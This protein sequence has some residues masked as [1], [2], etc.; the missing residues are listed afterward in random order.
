MEKFLPDGVTVE[1]IIT[2][3]AALATFA[4][5]MAIWSTGVIKDNMHGK[6]K[7]LQS[8]RTDLKR[9]YTTAAKRKETVKKKKN[10]GFMHDVVNKIDLIKNEAGV[11][12]KILLLQAGFRDK[13]ALTIFTFYKIIAPIAFGVISVILIYVVQI[14]EL[15]D[16]MKILVCLGATLFGAQTPE[17]YLKNLTGK[18]NLE[19]QR[20]LPDMLDL[21]VICSEAGLTLDAALNRVVK[22]MSTAHPELADEIAL[23]T[24]ELGFL[25]DRKTA[26]KNL[27]KRV[28]LPS[29]KA[30]SATLIQAEKYGTPLSTSLRVL[31]AEFRNERFMKA[32]EK[33]AKLPATMTIPLIMFILPTLFI[34]LMGPAACQISDNLVK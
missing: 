6:I 9:G 33:A 34:I 21:L 31:S 28:N 15:E 2:I 26:I 4:V 1:D 11:K 13:E 7:A 16:N 30:M 5:V 32:E 27:S 29:I 25:P 12:Y 22:E 19:M 10:S 8:R 18:R 3:T 17:I 14:T 24:V 20:S 23:T